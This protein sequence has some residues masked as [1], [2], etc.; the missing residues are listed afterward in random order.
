MGSGAL[1][2]TQGMTV[3]AVALL[4]PKR[5]ESG[6]CISSGRAARYRGEI[7]A[8]WYY[9]LDREYGPVSAAELKRLAEVGTIRPDTKVKNGSAGTWGPALQVK[10]LF[11][12]RPSSAQPPKPP[13]VPPP[14]R[15][16]PSAPV[17][18]PP[19]STRSSVKSTAK[20]GKG[21]RGPLMAVVGSAIGL[22]L[23]VVI[24][25]MLLSGGA[26]VE[27]SADQAGLSAK[28]KSV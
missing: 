13:P 8:D 28:G 27:E 21:G 17:P 23:I 6:L 5:I 2:C 3:P 1:A 15:A 20:G 19:N 9:L 12:K 18:E 11:A 10:G 16:E 26:A 22:V 25:G 7:M 4:I 24:A 14:P